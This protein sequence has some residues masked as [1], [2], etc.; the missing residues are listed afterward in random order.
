MASNNNSY[1]NNREGIRQEN[2]VQYSKKNRKKEKDKNRRGRI[3]NKG[4]RKL[5]RVGAPTPSQKQI[6][7]SGRVKKKR[8][9]QEKQ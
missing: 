8:C 5:A 3:K 6:D 2:T 1:N 4:R 7:I 9:P